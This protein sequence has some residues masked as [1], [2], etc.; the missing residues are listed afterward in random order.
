MSPF[1]VA[2]AIEIPK[3]AKYDGN[4]SKPSVEEF[5]KFA[6]KYSPEIKNMLTEKVDP[7]TGTETLKC[8]IKQ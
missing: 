7:A 2:S 8:L 5:M 4:I 6:R 1:Y 3:Q